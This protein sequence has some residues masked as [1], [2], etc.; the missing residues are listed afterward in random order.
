MEYLTS[1]KSNYVFWESAHIRDFTNN[2]LI[3]YTITAVYTVMDR[4]VNFEKS[5]NHDIW[6]INIGIPSL[7]T[8]PSGLQ[9]KGKIY[10]KWKLRDQLY[11]Y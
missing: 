2:Y 5:Q 9:I 1:Y 10:C 6:L 3:S 8:K 7:S 11:L 4:A